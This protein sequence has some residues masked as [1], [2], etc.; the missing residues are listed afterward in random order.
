MISNLS[1]S[2]SWHV[3]IFLFLISAPVYSEKLRE[4][5][6]NQ[7]C[8][9]KIRPK[10]M[11]MTTFSDEFEPWKTNLQ[12][13]CKINVPGVD[14]PIYYNDQGLFV[15]ITGETCPNCCNQ[16]SSLLL[17]GRFDFR[18]TYWILSGIAGI[19]PLAA[20]ISSVAWAQFIVNG[21]TAMEVDARQMPPTWPYGILQVFAPAPDIPTSFRPPYNSASLTYTLNKSLAMWAYKLT[22]DISLPFTPEMKAINFAYDPSYTKTRIPPK[23]M[24]GDSLASNRFWYGS[25][26]NQWGTN[27]ITLCTNG[28][29]HM[30]VSEEE[31]YGIADWFQRIGSLGKVDYER[32]LYLRGG[33]D[34]TF[35]PD[36]INR[37][38]FI[39]SIYHQTLENIF[40]VAYT[41]AEQLII[42]YSHYKDHLPCADLP[43][44]QD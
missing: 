34:Y 44:A 31:G 12:L 35:S 14:A 6:K 39:N 19:S 16:L 37:G 24:L 42:N 21:D 25:I 11:V 43:T 2:L 4:A 41:V 10:V 32:L 27:W 5:K 38:P 40:N 23:V 28:F 7:K 22:K 20:S 18:K 26:M 17:D 30:V 1:K 9:I 36:L 15:M 3:F 8:A 13:H 29:G 33:S